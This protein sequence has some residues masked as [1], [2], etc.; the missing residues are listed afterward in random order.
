M[1]NAFAL[2]NYGAKNMPTRK[3]ADD[4]GMDI[5]AP[6]EFTLAPGSTISIP[7]GFGTILPPN[8]Y[9][10]IKAR[11]STGKLGLMFVDNP[12]DCG[13]TGEVHAVVW[14]I[15]SSSVTIKAGERFC[16]L[17]VAPCICCTPAI[18]SPSDVEVEATER[19]SGCYGST[20][21]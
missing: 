7:L 18:Y 11:G 10:F 6:E 3:Y 21:R 15:G 2:I 5:F 4:A 12:I 20:G 16:Q 8:H 17:V 13:Y 14:N 9:A 1:Q 19:G